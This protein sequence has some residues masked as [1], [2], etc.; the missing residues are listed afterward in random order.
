MT[1]EYRVGHYF[2][3]MAMIEHLFGDTAHH[4]AQVASLGA[5]I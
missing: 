5:V 3:R 4:L 1:M 2:K